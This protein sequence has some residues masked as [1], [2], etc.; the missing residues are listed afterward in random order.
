M[1]SI[2]GAPTL[3]SALAA[4]SSLIGAEEG[5]VTVFCEDK[6]TLLAEKAAVLHAKGTFTATVTT[7]K[8]FLKGDR[9][10]LSKQGSVMEISSI[11]SDCADELHC[12]KKGAA[13]A[14][15]ETIAQLLSS[16]ADAALLRKSAE[17]TEGMLSHKLSDLAF[18][19]EKYDEFLKER[20]LLDENGYL[21]LLPQRIEEELR[22]SHIVFFAFPSFT[23]QAM[24]GVRAAIG[25][26]GKVTGIFLAG[27]GVYTNE[28]AHAFRLAAEEMGGAAS[29]ELPSDLAGDAAYV[30]EWLFSPEIYGR[31]RDRREHIHLFRAADESEEMETAC[32]VIKKH[33]LTEGLRY[34]DFAI[35][36]PDKARFA[37]AER[38]LKDYRI[39]FFSDRKR[40]LSEHPFCRFALDVLA[41]I[42]DGGTPDSVDAVLSSVYFGSADDYRNYLLKYGGYRGAVNREIKDGDAVKGYDRASLVELREKLRAVLALFPRTGKGTKYTAAVRSLFDLVGGAEITETL[43]EKFEGA[44]KEFLDVAPLYEILDEIDSLAGEMKFTALEFSDLLRS[45]LEAKEISMIPQ[46]ADAVFLGD[47]TE[48]RFARVPVLFLLGA[49]ESLPRASGDTAVITDGE[50][51][52]LEALSLEIEPQIK[53]VNMRAKESLYLN[54]C[55]FQRELYVGCPLRVMGEEARRGEA[56]LSID[57]MCFGAPMPETYLYKSCE[58]APALRNLLRLK[59]DYAAG[60]EQS[61][62]PYLSLRAMLQERE[63]LRPLSAGEKKPSEKLPALLFGGQISPSLL[64]SYFACPYASFAAHALRLREREERSVLDTDTGTFVHTVLE[65]TAPHFNE[66]ADE[67]ECGAAAESVARELLASPR[68]AFLTDT[69]AGAYTGE[70]LVK[71]CGSVTRACFRQVHFSDFSVEAEEREIYLPAIGLKGR[72]DRIDSCGDYVRIIDYKTGEIDDTPAAYYT[73][74]KLQLELYLLAASEGKVPAGAFYFPARDEFSGTDAPPFR[75][76]GFFVKDDGLLAHMDT[77]RT[78]GKSAFYEGGGRSEKCLPQEAFGDFL[79]YAVLVSQR[80]I[81]EMEAGNLAPSPYDGAC[82]YCKFRGMCGFSGVERKEAAVTCAQIAAIAKAERGE[83]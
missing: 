8:R 71:E 27:K 15:Y 35:L 50:I 56:F 41:C 18:V 17:E 75:M 65:Q 34:R 69:G 45:G 6:L 7:F 23:R 44:E 10:I 80:A 22:G 5:N 12:F 60:K 46:S 57:R 74:R 43:S 19:L 29:R 79:D 66:Y 51:K 53:V 52:R 30:A 36:L 61:L 70:R 31:E 54:L 24:E 28:A 26:G 2:I 1:T 13:Q 47:A 73:G 62:A 77:L 72:T 63:D 37:Q 42:H 39:P 4:L 55:S 76:K 33:V 32:A 14:V 38:M 21:A 48:S 49:D 58:R 3:D 40:A 82:K 9:A 83:K 64:E 78:E 11:L 68:Y 16:R 67:E 81:G 20:G 25:C 59:E